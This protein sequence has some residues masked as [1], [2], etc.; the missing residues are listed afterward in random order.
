[1][2]LTKYKIG[3]T[4]LTF[5]ENKSLSELKKE[6]WYPWYITVEPIYNRTKF[7]LIPYRYC[8]GDYA[9]EDFELVPFTTEEYLLNY[10]H[11]LE[12]TKGEVIWPGM[13]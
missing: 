13:Q 8:N 3:T 7:K 10:G 9:T 4:E 6:G 2:P 1:M 11:Y 12:S 5:L